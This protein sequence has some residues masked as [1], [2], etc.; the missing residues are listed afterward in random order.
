MSSSITHIAGPD[1]VWDGRYL[2]QR[3]AWCGATLIDQDL[4]LVAVAGDP[5]PFP[6]WPVGDLIRV[7]GNM[8]VVVHEFRGLFPGEE[9][10]KAPDDACLRLDPQVTA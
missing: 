7:D 3:C 10:T 8:T 4:T 9:P 1:I 6:T 2:R 5:A